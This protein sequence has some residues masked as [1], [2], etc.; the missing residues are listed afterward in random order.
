MPVRSFRLKLRL[1]TCGESGSL[2]SVIVVV[3]AV[4]VVVLV[5]LQDDSRMSSSLCVAVIKRHP[6]SFKNMLWEPPSSFDVV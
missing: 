1:C 6:P 4:L 5:V 3:A 2:S